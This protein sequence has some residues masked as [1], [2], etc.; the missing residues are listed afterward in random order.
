MP[1]YKTKKEDF[2]SL[3]TPDMAYVLG[4]F[5]ADGNITIGKRNNYYIEFTSTDKGI[6][7]K[8]KRR[9][10]SNHKLSSRK[11]NKDWK[12]AFRLQIGSKKIVNDLS[13]L[14][15]HQKKSLRLKYPD[16]P[17]RYFRHFV[18]GYFDGDGHA[19][20]GLYKKSNRSSPQRILYSGFTSGTKS[21]LEKLHRDLLRLRVVYGGTLYYSKGYRLN[22][23]IND[24]IAFYHFLYKN[25]NT[26]LY[27]SR[28]KKVFEK[29]MNKLEK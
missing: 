22:F 9:L 21:F 10:G 27:L 16:I 24:S 5:V 13:A 8:I 18:R 25:L 28:K 17:R 12:V 20:T 2:F 23:A 1:I 11:R 29:Y 14:G 4:F 19:V 15:L 26:D 6:L 7:K 3:W